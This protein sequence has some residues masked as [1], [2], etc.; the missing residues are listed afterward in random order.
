MHF[1][2][3]P[4]LI[5]LALATATTSAPIQGRRPYTYPGLAGNPPHPS[6]FDGLPDCLNHER[7]SDVI[8]RR[9]LLAFEQVEWA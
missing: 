3:A 6:G 5:A 4:A 1:D 8:L 2:A 9:R 7:L